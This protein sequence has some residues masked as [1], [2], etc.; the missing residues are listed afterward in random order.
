M[1]SDVSILL[2]ACLLHYFTYIALQISL[3]LMKNRRIQLLNLEHVNCY[4]K[5]KKA[6]IAFTSYNKPFRPDISKMRA[7][8]ATWTFRSTGLQ[9]FLSR[10]WLTFG[11]EM[12]FLSWQCYP[13]NCNAEFAI[14]AMCQLVSEYG[15]FLGCIANHSFTLSCTFQGF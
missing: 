10:G 2:L 9:S 3:D 15:V 8:S 1:F 6:L 13:C 5:S 12:R 7:R 11:S 4:S 14:H